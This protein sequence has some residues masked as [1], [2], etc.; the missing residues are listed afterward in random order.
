MYVVKGP[1]YMMYR[2]GCKPQSIIILFQ[3]IKIANCQFH[4]NET[5]PVSTGVRHVLRCFHRIF[6]RLQSL[7]FGQQ[8]KIRAYSPLYSLGFKKPSEPLFCR[9]FYC[10]FLHIK[11]K[12]STIWH[13]SKNVSIP[14]TSPVCRIRDAQEPAMTV[15]FEGP[16][17][18][19]WWI[20]VKEPK[21]H[22]ELI[23]ATLPMIGIT[24]ERST[25]PYSSGP[26]FVGRFRWYIYIYIY[27]LCRKDPN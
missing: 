24:K 20:W 4:R 16:P 1:Y 15:A 14:R 23:A 21:N 12:P 3:A 17:G 22:E 8:G 6:P 26:I 10:S 27:I 19:I 11:P 25:S 18:A 5:S 13:R 9:L 2:A 7:S